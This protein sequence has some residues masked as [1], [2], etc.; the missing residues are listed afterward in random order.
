MEQISSALQSSSPWEQVDLE[1]LMEDVLTLTEDI[2][3]TND[4][5]KLGGAQLLS[6]LLDTTSGYSDCPQYLRASTFQLIG[7]V[8]QN[9]SATQEIC[10]NEGI[11]PKLLSFLS[12]EKDFECLRKLL[13]AISCE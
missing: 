9:N 1:E 3:L 6:V 7:T 13:A 12:V 5:F 8:T 11:L 10:F 2:N 4:F